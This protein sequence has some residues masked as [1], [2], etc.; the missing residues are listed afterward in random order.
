LPLSRF[1]HGI[2]NIFDSSSGC[3]AVTFATSSSQV[4]PEA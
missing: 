4:M 3:R 2:P 1:R